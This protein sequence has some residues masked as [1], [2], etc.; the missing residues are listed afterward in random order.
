MRDELK[1][2]LRLAQ[3]LSADELP[4][5]LGDIE[6]VRVTAMSRISAPSATPQQPDRLLSADE[7]AARLGI[8][9]DYLYRHHAEYPFARRIGRRVLFSSVGL[10]SYIGQKRHREILTARRPSRTLSPVARVDGDWRME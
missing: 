9:K 6:T 7:A 5:F 3:Q 8:S 4:E 10:E 2:A 1:P